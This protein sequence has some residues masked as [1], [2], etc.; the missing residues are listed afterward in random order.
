MLV[1]LPGPVLHGRADVAVPD[2]EVNDVEAFDLEG[3]LGRLIELDTALVALD[4]AQAPARETEQNMVV[5]QMT[6]GPLPE[7]IV[8]PK[9]QG[10]MP[11]G[12]RS[13]SR[14]PAPADRR[15]VANGTA[16]SSND[17][18]VQRFHIGGE[19]V[20]MEHHQNDESDLPIL[21]EQLAAS[22]RMRAR[23]SEVAAM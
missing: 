16:A 7:P 12:V 6:Q 23:A 9:S 10:R 3:A 15:D 19:D 17:G 20:P 13:Q 5:G 4:G 22:E 2:G 11:N 14:G 1:P 21:E 18:G 8:V